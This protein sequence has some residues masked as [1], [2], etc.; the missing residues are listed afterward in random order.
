VNEGRLFK[1]D[2]FVLLLRGRYKS[3]K[4]GL[5]KIILPRGTSARNYLW[6][7]GGGGGWEM[8]RRFLVWKSCIRE[9]L[10]MCYDYQIIR[11]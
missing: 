4:S 8:L 9:L 3:A 5:S 7:G 10:Q 11:I 1:M 6:E 2:S